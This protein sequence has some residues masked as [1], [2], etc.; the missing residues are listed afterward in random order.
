MPMKE[1]Y[2]PANEA[3]Q[4]LDFAMKTPKREALLLS[5]SALVQI[6]ASPS[7]KRYNSIRK[8]NFEQEDRKMH[9]SVRKLDFLKQ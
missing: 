6:G 4:Q 2:G 9:P 5:P 8:I 3:R 7:S 1:E